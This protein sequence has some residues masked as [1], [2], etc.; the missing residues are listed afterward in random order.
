M[1][2][3]ATGD[4][5]PRLI[6]T[7]FMGAGKSTIG[8]AAAKRLGTPF[9]DTDAEIERTAGRTVAEIFA[10]DG[11]PAFREL[12]RATVL[13]IVAEFDG[14][15][16]LGGGSVTVAG[17]REA[18]VGLPLIHLRVTPQAGFARVANSDRPLLAGDDPRGTY[19]RLLA[20]RTALY[21]SV[22]TAAVDADQPVD[23][24]VADVL[25]ILDPAR[26]DT[27]S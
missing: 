18:L 6:L 14:V 3:A 7:G 15:V 5:G 27:Q 9:I 12:E 2:D 21:D 10:T 23:A 25:A 22:A 11:E 24:V 26:K 16:A 8:R 20:R 1:T 19:D 17:I 13:R 4:R